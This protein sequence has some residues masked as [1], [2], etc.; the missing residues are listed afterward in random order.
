[1]RTITPGMPIGDRFRALRANY[2]ELG[3]A[4]AAGDASWTDREDP[5][6]IADWVPLFTPI[7]AAAWSA[8]RGAGLPLWP[9]LPVGRYFVDF[10]CPVK[11]VAV[12]CDGAKWHDARKDARRDNDLIGMGWVTYRAPGWL[13]VA[14]DGQAISRFI[15]DIAH[16]WG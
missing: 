2:A 9:Q 12:E 6:Q 15:K 16:H 4:V 5:Y 7:E 8:I 1:M 3:V 10:G 14:E 13:C 11:K